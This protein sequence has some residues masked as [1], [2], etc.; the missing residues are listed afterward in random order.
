MNIKDLQSNW[1]ALAKI[2]PMWAVLTN[3]ERWQVEE[4]FETGVME[5]DALMQYIEKSL[6]F[7]FEKGKVLDF[8]C[9]VGRL[10]QAL[11]EYFD[12][13]YGV[14]IAPSMV[15]LAREY[16]KY[17][18]KCKYYLNSADNL[19]IFPDNTFDFIYSN[20]TLQHIEPRY[21]RNYIKEFLRILVPGGLLVFQLPS[22]LIVSNTVKRV[23]KRMLPVAVLELY[24]RMKYRLISFWSAQPRIEM[25][26]IKRDE[27]IK[28]LEKNKA[29]IVDIRQDHSQ[30]AHPQWIC[31]MYFVSKKSNNLR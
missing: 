11:A 28:F 19:N 9:G 29:T 13:V 16:N 31:Y 22:E 5:I 3:S 17:G 24:R 1:D 12:E 25:Y 21:T 27:I 15:E 2:N 26:G 7:S 14:D 10:S 18:D 20:I 6:Q 30:T 23:I 8:G 4:F